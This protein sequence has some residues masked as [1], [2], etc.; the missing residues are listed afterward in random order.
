MEIAAS[1]WDTLEQ[2]AG[3]AGFPVE[4]VGSLRRRLDNSSPRPGSPYS[5]LV[6]RPDAGIE[7]LL[8]RWIS[9]DAADELQKVGERPLVIG[10]SPAE[11]KPKLGVWPNWRWK[12]FE[13]GHLLVLRTPG[14]V[15]A[16]IVSQLASL[17]HLDQ[18]VIVSR[19]N[20]AMHQHE[21][22]IAAS[23]ATVAAT[24]RVLLVALPGE[25]PTDGELAEVAAL[26]VT[27]MR[28]AGF[29]GGRCLGAATWFTGG[30]RR[31]GTIAD[32]GQFLRV[33][34]AETIAGRGGLA[35]EAVA[36]L[37]TDLQQH[38]MA[39]TN[40]VLA[41]I[42]EIESDR[43]TKE[44][45]NHLGDLGKELAR[46]LPRRQDADTEF[47]RT[48]AMDALRSWGAYTSIEGHWMKYVERLRPGM[49]AEFFNEAEK[50]MSLLE[51]EPGQAPDVSVVPAEIGQSGATFFDWLITQAKR[52]GIALVC[53]LT[54]YIVA[55][56]FV[57]EG[58]TG[59]P[60][61]V[62]T[63]LDYA[64]LVIAFV[65]GFAIATKIFRGHRLFLPSGTPS[66]PVM[67][68]PSVLGWEQLER[69]LT[70]WFS[71]HIRS[72][73]SSPVDDCAALAKRLKIDVV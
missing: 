53:G 41:P 73:P 45:A 63:V 59:L 60:P 39:S 15:P 64:A 70:A 44:L 25:E 36:N 14:K 68:P 7:L 27:R 40:Q 58:E 30:E 49:Q 55:Y 69:R 24:A 57:T 35:H 5:L 72:K 1:D 13:N 6:G 31:P 18:V 20:Q 8:A 54:A 33:D 2:L 61:L 29:R 43:L 19:L 4:R 3:R 22:D 16:D 71:Q 46:Q 17:G 65:L 42:D 34:S 32:V 26:A 51:F 66:V 48:Y 47:V 38:A 21:C 11:V 28:Q 52:L 10:A 37:L 9:P 62:I 23:L 50:G 67:T 12:R 56:K